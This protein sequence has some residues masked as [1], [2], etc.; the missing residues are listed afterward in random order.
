MGPVEYSNNANFGWTDEALLNQANYIEEQLNKN[1][2]IKPGMRVRVNYKG[3]SLKGKTG[4]VIEYNP[5]MFPNTVVA[6]DGLWKVDPL[7]GAR[8]IYEEYLDIIEEAE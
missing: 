5:Y 8:W 7:E 6:I 1:I 2:K 4:T 3:G